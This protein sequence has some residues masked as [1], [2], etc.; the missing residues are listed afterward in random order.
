MANYISNSPEFLGK[1]AT[2]VTCGAVV[3]RAVAHSSQWVLIP[4]S[5]N[6]GGTRAKFCVNSIFSKARRR[7]KTPIADLENRLSPRLPKIRLQPSG[8][9]LKQ[10]AQ[11]FGR[12]LTG[13]EYEAAGQIEGWILLKRA[14]LGI[15]GLLG[16]T[17]DDAADS[18]PVDRARAR[19]E[20]AR[21]TCRACSANARS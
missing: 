16:L 7:T 17:I 21:P 19:G 11:D 9:V 18:R 14:G 2:S 1:A 8:F 20:G 3:N 15:Q 12:P 13:G 4:R 6:G 5:H 10:R